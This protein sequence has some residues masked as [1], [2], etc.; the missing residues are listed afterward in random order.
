M[1]TAARELELAQT[2]QGCLGKA[3]DDEPV[4]ILRAQDKLAADLVDLWADRAQ[5]N[6]CGMAKVIEA[7]DL[8]QKMRAWPTQ[9]FPD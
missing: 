1:A 3:A 4:F 9:K 5:A 7:M 8:A 2:G 6:G